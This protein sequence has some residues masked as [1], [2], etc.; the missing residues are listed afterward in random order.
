M[1]RLV[2]QKAW[3]SVSHYLK[4][5]PP[6]EPG[7]PPT[8]ARRPLLEALLLGRSPWLLGK[9]SLLALKHNVWGAGG[10]LENPMGKFGRYKKEKKKRNR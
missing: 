7:E 9:E 5:S 10:R 4:K 2:E 3:R 1:T 8:L 6:G